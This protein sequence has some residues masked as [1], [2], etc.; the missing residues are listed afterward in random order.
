V[1]KVVDGKMLLAF[2]VL[3]KKTEGPQAT[4]RDFQMQNKATTQSPRES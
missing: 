2:S 1:R 4:R 3:W